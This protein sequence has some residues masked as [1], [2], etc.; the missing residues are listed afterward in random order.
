MPAG[1]GGVA[2]SQK[3]QAVGP[4]DPPVR[5]VI[6]GEVSQP[7]LGA[8]KITDVEHGTSQRQPGLGGRATS[9][10]T[11]PSPETAMDSAAARWP[12]SSPANVAR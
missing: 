7:D 3:A 4:C 8:V 9:L 6:G 2:E 5:R 1:C 11:V 12:E 10:G